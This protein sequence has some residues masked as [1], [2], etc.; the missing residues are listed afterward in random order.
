V[1]LIPVLFLALV[2]FCLATANTEEIYNIKTDSSDS[3]SLISVREGGE[4]VDEAFLISALPFSGTGNTSDN[5]DDY[6]EACPYEG[7]GPDVVYAYTPVEDSA[8]DIDLCD[9]WYFAKLYVYENAVTP[10]A[11]YTCADF[12]HCQ[13]FW[14][15][16][17]L[18]GIDVFA[19]NTYYIIVDGYDG[20]YG[21]YTLHVS[22]VPPPP[23]PCE[24]GC[25]AGGVDEG[26]PPLEY[27]YIDTFNGGCWTPPY[28]FQVIDYPEL[29]ARSGW[30]ACGIGTCPDYDFF[31]VMADGGGY[32]SV[33]VFSEYDMQMCLWFPT[34]CDSP[35]LVASAT[36]FCRTPG[37]IEFPLPPALAACLYFSPAA[38]YSPEIEFDYIVSLS[39]IQINEPTSIDGTSWGRIKNKFLS[40]PEDD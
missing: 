29:C 40:S 31:T 20:D 14:N 35:S 26:E 3:T 28:V 4:V 34:G 8:I 24:L 37:I 10:G 30:Y 11:P 5:I 39:G 13:H 27:N 36:C 15:M 16:S 1:R 22:E 33:T 18:H 25:P 12:S 19:G 32:I 6:N 9:S 17:D 38:D 2:V 7:N 21:D 23:P